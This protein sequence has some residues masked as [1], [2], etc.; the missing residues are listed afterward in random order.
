[1][2]PKSKWLLCSIL[3]AA[4]TPLIAFAQEQ[5]PEV[6]TAEI[7][8][9]GD[10]VTYI[11]GVMD[12]DTAAAADSLAPPPDDS[13]KWFVT[14]ITTPNCQH[15]DRLKADLATS[16]DLR[17]FVNSDDPKASWAHLNFYSATDRTQQFRWKNLQVTQYP[18]I[19]VQPP[20]NG[21]FGSPKTVVMQQTGYYG[22]DQLAAALRKSITTYAQKFR[23]VQSQ[24]VQQVAGHQQQDIGVD[25]PFAIPLPQP[26]QPAVYPFNVPPQAPFAPCPAP[27]PQ[28]ALP[29]FSTVIGWVFSV[30]GAGGITNSLV[31]ILIG[32]QVWRAYRK[33]NNLPLLLDDSTFEKLKAALL[34]S[35][36]NKPKV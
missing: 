36:H 31:T 23:N 34:D 21:S 14:V 19:L 12:D 20:A 28:P 26:T 25:P 35:F 24:T 8:R 9:R 3:L 7:L 16:A 27:V 32:V 1:M 11:N 2:F 30:L 10:M 4:L 6:D 13:H 29:S 15:C 18:T 22:A 17:A 5:P 33:A